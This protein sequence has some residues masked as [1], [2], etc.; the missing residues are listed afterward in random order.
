MLVSEE[1]HGTNG[2]QEWLMRYHGQNLRAPI[3][4]DYS[5]KD[6]FI[7]WHVREVFRGRTRYLYS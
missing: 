6:T 4:P 7:N 3:H 5:P 1:A 2:F